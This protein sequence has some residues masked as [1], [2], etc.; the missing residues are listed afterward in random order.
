MIQVY[1]LCIVSLLALTLFGCSD[2]GSDAKD[3]SSSVVTSPAHRMVAKMGVG[4]NLGNTLEAPDEGSWGESLSAEGI[5]ALA[6]S[7]FGN[8]R[9][10]VRW[11][12]H[13]ADSTADSCTVN[14]EWMARVTWAVDQVIGNGMIAVVNA[15][16]WAAM[17]TDPA[18]TESCFLDVYQQMAANFKSYSKDSLVIELLNE[19]RDSLDASTWNTLVAKTISVIRA[20]DSTR[21]IMV[22]GVNYSASTS[23]TSLELPAKDS[24]LI[25]TFHYYEPFAFTHQGAT[26]IDPTYPVGTTWDA[27]ASEK[28][29]IRDAFA[30]VKTWADKNSRPVYL[31]EFGAYNEADSTSRELWTEFVAQEALRLGFACAY[32]EFSSSFGIYDNDNDVWHQYLMNALLHPSHGFGA[33]AYPNL[34]TLG[35]VLFDDFDGFDSAYANLNPISAAL[36]TQAG[37][38]LDSAKGFWYAYHNADSRAYKIDGSILVTGDL[39]KYDSTLAKGTKVEHNLMV[40]DDGYDGRS[41]Y[42]KFNLKGDNYPYVGVGTSINGDSNLFDF[43][44][45]IA[46]TFK[47]KGRGDFKIAWIT[48]FTDSCCADNWGKF[49]TEIT[50]DSTWQEYTIW[51]DQWAPS[52]YS[53]LEAQ[54]YEWADHHDGIV[55]FQLMNGQGYGEVADDTLEIW[56]D[57]LRF[58][59]MK[60]SDFGIK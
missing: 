35:Y 38:P 5:K 59:G 34:D 39:I 21:T 12:T 52:P 6:D 26:F 27:S 16:H 30:K 50:L 60:N 48:A 14:S 15:H 8:I 11:D 53:D 45:L 18:G 1:K 25:V 17:Y 54:G 37:K 55:H 40:I 36:T 42:A 51:Y 10:P 3:D 44:S 57:D 46:L 43:G 33:D 19:P 47:A 49:S 41:L 29:T 2:S 7:G 24:N 58:Y 31:G 9:I 22:G 20:E 28:R 13:L 56:V 32:W 23:V 4:V